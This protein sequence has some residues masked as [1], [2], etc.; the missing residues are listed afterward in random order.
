MDFL[1]IEL[2]LWGGLFFLFW[3]LKDGLGQVESNMNSAGIPS[4]KLDNRF[5]Y[6]AP[7]AMSERIGTYWDKPIFRYAVIGGRDYQYDRIRFADDNSRLEENECCVEP[8]LVYVRCS[9]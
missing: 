4:P 6:I 7:E 8:G 9:A 1:L 5:A 2:I 3:A